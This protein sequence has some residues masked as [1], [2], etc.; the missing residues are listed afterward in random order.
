M[1][2]LLK[3]KICVHLQLKPINTFIGT[4]INV[5]K[6]HTKAQFHVAPG[7]KHEPVLQIELSLD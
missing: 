2:N 3:K 5:H 7:L 6:F 1:K 4:F